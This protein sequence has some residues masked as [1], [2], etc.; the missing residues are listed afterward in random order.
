MEPE[1]GLAGAARLV[2]VK[3]VSFLDP[4]SVVF[5][6]M[7]AGWERQQRVRF[8]KLD[9]IQSRLALVRRLAT[10]S[11]LYPWQ[12]T[13]GEVEAFLAHRRSGDRPVRCRRCGGMSVCCGCFCS[14]S[15]IRGTGGQLCVSSGSVPRLRW[16]C[17][18]STASGT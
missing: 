8:L 16:C 11:N 15:P 17:T 13:A 9:T 1:D 14:T 7:L 2:L 10:E 6:A 12:W 5:E 18:S 4:E 3:G